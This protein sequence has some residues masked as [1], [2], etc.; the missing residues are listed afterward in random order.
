[1]YLA[2]IQTHTNNNNNNK[3]QF[4]CKY[5]K[6]QKNNQP[7]NFIL[8]IYVENKK[9]KKPINN[10]EKNW[11][12]KLK[13]ININKCIMSLT[14]PKIWVKRF[15]LEYTHTSKHTRTRKKEKKLLYIHK[16]HHWYHLCVSHIW[17]MKHFKM[18]FFFQEREILKQK[19][20]F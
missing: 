16:T 2:K 19:K 8:S 17:W 1:M 18:R 14:K 6:K 4:L 13:K 12:K 20:N 11:K 3:N 7:T 10:R 15:S 5:L 9:A